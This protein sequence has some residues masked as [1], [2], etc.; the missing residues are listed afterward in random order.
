MCSEYFNMVRTTAPEY[1]SS[2]SIFPMFHVICSS[3]NKTLPQLA[4]SL[5]IHKICQKLEKKV[6]LDAQNL[7]NVRRSTWKKVINKIYWRGEKKK[8]TSLT[9]NSTMRVL[10]INHVHFGYYQS[11]RAM[12]T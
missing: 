6:I 3:N 5:Y 10:S 4:Q 12:P 9:Y 8:K 1:C 2:L 11:H 7:H